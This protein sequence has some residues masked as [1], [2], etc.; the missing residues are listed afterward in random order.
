MK[1]AIF[2][3]RKECGAVA[4]RQTVVKAPSSPGGGVDDVTGNTPA[5]LPGVNAREIFINL[6]FLANYFHRTD[7]EASA[8]PANGSK[9]SF[10]DFSSSTHVSVP[11]SLHSNFCRV[12]LLTVSQMSS[13]DLVSLRLL[14]KDL[15]ACVSSVSIQAARQGY[16]LLF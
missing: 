11:M 15:A 14:G 2:R 12:F 1:K 16:G 8:P 10:F 5:A 7:N 6:L 9:G 13:E 3:F 4:L